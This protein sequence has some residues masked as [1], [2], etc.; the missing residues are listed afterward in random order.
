MRTATEAVF[1]GE[2][3][4]AVEKTRFFGEINPNYTR[5][6]SHLTQTA[7][8]AAE[9][10]VSMAQS[11]EETDLSQGL[12][13]ARYGHEDEPAQRAVNRAAAEAAVKAKLIN[14]THNKGEIEYGLSYAGK[15]LVKKYGTDSLDKIPQVTE[16]SGRFRLGAAVTTLAGVYGA[17]RL[18]IAW[19]DESSMGGIDDQLSYLQGFVGGLSFL[20]MINIYANRTRCLFRAR[21][22]RKAYLKQNADQSE[23]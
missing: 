8:T 18:G 15:N 16:A 2:L 7:I 6:N 20:T 4:A 10:I 5:E 22:A 21:T 11:A 19:A 17:H 14:R 12:P 1:T 23:L 13:V 3:A 9:C